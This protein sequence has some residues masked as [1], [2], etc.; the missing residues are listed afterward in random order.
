MSYDDD[1]L[2]LY[3]ALQATLGAKPASTLMASLPPVPWNEFATK[4]DLAGV[5]GEIAQLR[6][7]F[8]ELRGEFAELRGEFAELRGEIAELRGEI[9][10]LVPKMMVANVVT[11]GVLVGAVLAIARLFT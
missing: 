8:A 10:G 3:T 2:E 4:A 11:T 7:E 6:G 1:R 9:A 5:R